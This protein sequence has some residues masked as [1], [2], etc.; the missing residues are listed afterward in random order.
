[1][2]RTRILIAIVVLAVAFLSGGVIHAITNGQPDG[3]GHPYVG[4]LVFYVHN[5]S[6]QLVPA[7]FCSGSLIAP[8]VVLTAGHCTDGAEAAQAWFNQSIAGTGFPDTGGV[9][10]TKD[11]IHTHPEF[12]WNWHDI[13]RWESID[14]GVVVLSEPV[15]LADYAELPT[16]G[17]V[18]TLRMR[19]NV[20]IV[21]YGGQLKL[22]ESGPPYYR[23]AENG[24]RYYAP[25]QIVKSDNLNSDMWLKLTANP[26]QGKGGICYGDS[27]GPDLLGG[28]NI[29]LATNSFV[30]NA[31]CAGVNYSNRVDR[32]VVLDWVNGFL[33]E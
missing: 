9:T 14:T 8:T 4:I 18:D 7:W 6:D 19:T 17:L 15:E 30:A 5:S 33:Q 29:I 25:S 10:A 27:G 11:N 20:D 1:M 12:S 26:G 21:G 22:Q 23:W 2:R 16:A 32:Q 24:R 3:N 13:L 31:N 28:S